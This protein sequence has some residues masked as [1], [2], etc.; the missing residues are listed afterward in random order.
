[1]PPPKR[2]LSLKEVNISVNK[3]RYKKWNKKKSGEGW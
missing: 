2:I 1:M 3:K